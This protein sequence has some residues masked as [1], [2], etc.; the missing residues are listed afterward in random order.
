MK[1]L[2]QFTQPP[3]VPNP[4]KQNFQY[5]VF[6]SQDQRDSQTVC[7]GL[8]IKTEPNQTKIFAAMSYC[9]DF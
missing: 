9:I 3:V 5:S 8:E 1:I 7:N 6:I 4:V 2:S